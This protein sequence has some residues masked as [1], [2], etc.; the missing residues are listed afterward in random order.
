MNSLQLPDI[1]Y[2]LRIFFFRCDFFYSISPQ[3]FQMKSL[4]QFLFMIVLASCS[5]QAQDVVVH[6][7]N[8]KPRST[9]I[10][11]NHKEKAQLVKSLKDKHEQIPLHAT[12]IGSFLNVSHK[13]PKNS[14]YQIYDDKGVEFLVGRLTVNGVIPVKSLSKGTYK[15]HINDKP[16][17]WFI[18]K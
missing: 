17:L 5:L 7:H 8:D 10:I 18:K 15:L 13:L 4:P 12:P 14:T 9:T 11:S 16:V 2:T 3:Y 1:L 6:S